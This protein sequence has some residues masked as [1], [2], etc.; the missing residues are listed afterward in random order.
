MKVTVAVNLLFLHEKVDICVSVYNV[1]RHN[2]KHSNDAHN[3]YIMSSILSGDNK[4]LLSHE[5]KAYNYLNVTTISLLIALAAFHL[6]TA[7]YTFCGA[8]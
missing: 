3:Q 8:A 2:A 6:R 7:N 4:C 5:K 1:H